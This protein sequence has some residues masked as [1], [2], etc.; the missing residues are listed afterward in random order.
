MSGIMKLSILSI[1]AIIGLSVYA[2]SQDR[3]LSIPE[4]DTMAVTSNELS[5]EQIYCLAQNIY[6]EAGNQSLEGMA[7]VADVT[8]NR[9]QEE[10]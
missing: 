1:L 7:A 3:M 10:R 6:F 5:D 8:L 4:T 9:V 2:E